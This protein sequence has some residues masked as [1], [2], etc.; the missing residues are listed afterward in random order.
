VTGLNLL[1]LRNDTIVDFPRQAFEEVRGELIQGL[2]SPPC[3]VSLV[4][5][6]LPGCFGQTRNSPISIRQV[7]CD[8]LD[9]S[10]GLYIRPCRLYSCPWN[11]DR[12]G[13]SRGSGFH[14]ID[15]FRSRRFIPILWSANVPEVSRASWSRRSRNV[16]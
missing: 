8:T 1:Q 16:C 7:L 12:L 15:S 5:F 4:P 3:R 11:S 10:L 6:E 9:R 13:S 2:R 14:C